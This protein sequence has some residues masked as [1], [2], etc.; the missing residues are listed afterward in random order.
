MKS[1]LRAGRRLLLA[2]VAV[3]VLL[4]PLNSAMIAVAV[5]DIQRVFAVSF[6]S[7]SLLISVFYVASAVGQPVMGRLADRFGRRRLFLAGLVLS[8]VASGLAAIAPS[9]GA[10]LGFRA[11]QAVGTSAL[12]P[13]GLGIV[14]AEVRER[15]AA[16]LGV[17]TVS[18]SIS[19]AV[20][21]TVGGLLVSGVGSAAVFWINVPLAVLGLV[22]ALLA[23]P[24]DRGREDVRTGGLDLPGVA[25]FVVALAGLLWF[26][27]SLPTGAAWWS[28]PVGLVAGAA[29]VRRE[30]TTPVPIVD[31]HGVVTNRAL[32]DVYAQFL[33]V[34][35]IFYSVFFGVPSYLEHARGLSA[36]AA[37]LM[38][39]PVAGLGVVMTPLAARLTSRRGP[40]PAI[41]IGAAALGAGAAGLLTVGAHESLV[42][43]G[44]VLAVF[45]S[46]GGFNNLGLQA[47]L[48]AA[49]DQRDTSA[50]AGLFQTCRYL[51]AIAATS[52]L[53]IAFAHG[54]GTS[55]L[56][57]VGVVLVV[58]AAAALV[59]ALRRTG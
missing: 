33:L 27:L 47:A 46:A 36:A 59:M 24:R 57:V 18:A 19:A 56:H 7:A 12:F 39:L 43:T 44:V 10:L 4:N 38:M 45:G 37:G 8:A 17:L 48:Y 13:A 58:L 1:E 31:V 28:L 21:P 41:V 26:A 9:F 16:A 5:A 2:A 35:A 30:L 20:G 11:L 53:G 34:S 15:Q 23:L 3:G 14:R 55:E 22:L 51:G 40:K 25:L 52:L 42:L 50:A 29:F 6:R 32:L 54:I 49:V